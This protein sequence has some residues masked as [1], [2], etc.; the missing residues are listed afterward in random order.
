MVSPRLS[1]LSQRTPSRVTRRRAVGASGLLLA[2]ITTTGLVV[3]T[4]QADA[5]QPPGSVTCSSAG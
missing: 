4:P 3:A 5:E 1:S 2:A